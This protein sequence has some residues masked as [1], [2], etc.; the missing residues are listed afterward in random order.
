LK[1]TNPI[2]LD[3]LASTYVL[4]TLGGGARR[5]FERLQADRYDV[6]ELVAQWNARLSQLAESIPPEQPSAEL[7]KRIEQQTRP[8]QKS[9]PWFGSVRSPV[10]APVLSG[11]GGLAAGIALVSA[12][13]FWSPTVL[14]TADQ[15]AMR[16]GERLPQSYVG[17][18]VDANSNGKVLLSSL[19][20]GR[21][22]TIKAIGP[23]A[24]PAKGHLV[25]WALPPGQPALRIGE[26]PTKGVAHYG[27]S[28]SSE[29]LFATVTKL[30]VTLEDTVAPAT[31]GAN[32][33]FTGNCAKLW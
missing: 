33:V 6:R 17:L 3:H 15:I 27:M 9:R 28:D 32:V 24:A 20:F 21:T 18:L 10:F 8:D 19:R 11:L 12:L 13:L 22:A 31:I 16:S 4:G 26:V 5:R 14:I 1:Y 30:V 29:K 2:V 23:I 25:L 7:W